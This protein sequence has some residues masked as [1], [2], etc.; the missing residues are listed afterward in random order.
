MTQI[1][2]A[3][4]EQEDNSR[5]DTPLLEAKGFLRKTE[6]TSALLAQGLPKAPYPLAKLFGYLTRRYI[7]RLPRL[8]TTANGSHFQK[9]TTDLE[10]HEVLT[11]QYY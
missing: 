6:L 10:Y 4:S 1:R 8:W 3:E 2:D 7:L 5:I 11:V 9:A